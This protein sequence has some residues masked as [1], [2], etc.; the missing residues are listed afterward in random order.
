VALLIHAASLLSSIGVSFV[1]L[2]LVDVLWL[3]LKIL[4]L[5]PPVLLLDF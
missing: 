4:G 2:E 5:K 3:S 1:S